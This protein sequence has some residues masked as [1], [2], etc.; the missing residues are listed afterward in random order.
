MIKKIIRKLNGN[1]YTRELIMIPIIYFRDKIWEAKNFQFIR[2][3]QKKLKEYKNIHNGGRCFIIGNGPSLR[4]RDLESIKGE[5]S[6]ASNRIFDLYSKTEWRPTYYGIQDFYVLKEISEEVEKEELGSKVRFIVS[7]RPE[8][9]CHDMKVDKK[10]RFFYL[11][12]CLSENRTVKFATDFSKTVGHGGTITYAMIQLAIYMGFKEIYLLGID[13]N[14]GK[15]I[16]NQGRYNKN[17]HA[18]SHF[19]G[20]KPYKNL[21]VN[22]VPHKRGELYISTKAYEVANVYAIDHNIHIYNTTRGGCLEVFER[23]NFDEVL[24]EFKQKKE[25]ND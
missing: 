18:D 22:N 25:T 8:Y 4:V 17:I 6:F 7:N 11:G 23:K 16:D 13:H 21:K 24:R 9:M 10:N 3:G 15:F 5:L 2:D 20:I 1:E 19:A 14:Y 12:T